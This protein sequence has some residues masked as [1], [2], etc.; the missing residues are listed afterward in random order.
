MLGIEMGV[1]VGRSSNKVI[2][3][4]YLAWSHDLFWIIAAGP[5]CS[6]CLA[7]PK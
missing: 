7:F 4:F 1:G 2:I 3:S 5:L 6:S